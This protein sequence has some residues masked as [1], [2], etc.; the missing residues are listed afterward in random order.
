ME[1][2]RACTDDCDKIYELVQNTIKA[3][4]PKYYPKEVVD[5]FCELHNRDNILK[6]IKNNCVGV[7][8]DNGNLI[9]TG[10]YVENHI[11]RVYV[12]PEY[13]KKGYGSYIM[14]CLENTI[15]KNFGTVYLDASLPASHLYES[16]GYKTIEH[17]KWIVENGVV[18]VY[19]IME[20]P[21]N[22]ITTQINYDG[23]IFTAKENSENGEVDS[24][25]T[26]YYHQ[27]G[28]TIWAEYFGGEILKGNLIGTVKNNGELDF[29]Y[30]HINNQGL[31]KIGKCHS[32]PKILENGKIEL[33]ENWQWLNGDLSKGDSVLIEK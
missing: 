21:L 27:N 7:L 20:K 15:S 28:N 19:E 31:V 1:Y 16:R 11:T 8:I 9:G 5:F 3:V 22:H 29:Y 2:I 18:L 23:K 24:S 12:P 13:Q 33:Y 4:Y 32:T 30:Q 14:N 6:D 17:K 26:F 25:T 10:S